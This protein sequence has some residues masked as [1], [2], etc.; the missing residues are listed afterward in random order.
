MEYTKMTK[1][2]L[3]SLLEEQSHLKSAVEAKD[4]EISAVKNALKDA[5]DAAANYPNLS[6][7]F[8]A[9][10]S[11][12]EALRKHIESTPKVEAMT[13][14]LE[15]LR[16]QNAEFLSK[17]NK[18]LGTFNRYINMTRAFMKSV[19]GSLENAVEYEALIQEDF[20]K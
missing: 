16:K 10:K 9:V 8:E 18:L 7:M 14:E 12:N 4:A 19:Q 5:K 15:G 13:K 1:Q 3:I 17:Y 6:K 2:D 11:E 20:T